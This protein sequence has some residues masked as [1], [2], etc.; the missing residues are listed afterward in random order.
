ME[1]EN[2]ELPSGTNVSK[3]PNIKG[4]TFNPKIVSME[5]SPHQS[6]MPSIKK[7]LEET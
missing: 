6:A 7:R 4:K 5:R 1:Q 2:E 3:V